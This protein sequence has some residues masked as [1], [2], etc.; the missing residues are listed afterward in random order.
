MLN[1]NYRIMAKTK[2]LETV[3]NT[4]GELPSTG[5]Q[6]PEFDLVGQELNDITL[7]SLKGKRV[8]L[9]IFPSLD[10]D[11]CAT[12]VRKFNVEASELPNTVVLCVS[13][14]LPFAAKRFCTIN[15]IKNVVTGS[16]FRSD[17]GKQYG[18]E[19]VDGPLRGLYARS[20]VIIDE[21][22]KVIG[23]MMCENITDEPDYELAKTLLA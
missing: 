18:V 3:V 12:S 21:N 23:T 5:T 8:V 10:T 6:A 9:N 22:G 11:V 15:G 7:D 17:F 14:D 19:M 20:L 2:F 4:V 16:G 1:Y 13:M